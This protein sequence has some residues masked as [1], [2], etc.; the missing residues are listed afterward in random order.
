MMAVLNSRM[1]TSG[2]DHTG[3][4][5]NSG[6]PPLAFHATGPTVLRTNG[7]DTF[8]LSSAMVDREVYDEEYGRKR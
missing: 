7:D 3:D 2:R 1:I 4:I 6:V 5:A 8:E